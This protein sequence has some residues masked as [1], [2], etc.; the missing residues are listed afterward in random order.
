LLVE[1]AL[2]DFEFP[3]RRRSLFQQRLELRAA[4]EA[5]LDLAAGLLPRSDH[6]TGARTEYPVGAIRIE[7]QERQ[8]YLSALAIDRRHP[9]GCLR[10][11]RYGSLRLGIGFLIGGRLGISPAFRCRLLPGFGFLPFV[12]LCFL[13]R[14]GFGL[15][16]RRFRLLPGFGIGPL[17]GL[18]LRLGS[19]LGGSSLPRLGFS[20]LPRFGFGALPRLD[21]GSLLCF[22]FGSLPRRGFRLGLQ[23]CLLLGLLPR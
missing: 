19:C 18:V 16:R 15:S 21:L 9:K 8:G 7:A 1:V 10:D 14:F 17:P 2:V 11:L 13:F 12:S 6:V 22:G 23:L 4:Q 3:D 5:G 20:S